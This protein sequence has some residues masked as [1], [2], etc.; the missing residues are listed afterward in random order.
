MIK[1][2][3]EYATQQALL[4][5]EG[6]PNLIDPVVAGTDAVTIRSDDFMFYYA[7]IFVSSVQYGNRTTLCSILK[8]F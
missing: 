2:T 5:D 6:A 1:E 7:D 4:R 3:N 8:D